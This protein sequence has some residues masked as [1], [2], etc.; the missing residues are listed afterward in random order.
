M[1]S[2]SEY[3]YNWEFVDLAPTTGT[4]LYGI[5][6]ALVTSIIGSRIGLAAGDAL[7]GLRR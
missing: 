1:E 4:F 3:H 7:R 6:V 5:G 2:P